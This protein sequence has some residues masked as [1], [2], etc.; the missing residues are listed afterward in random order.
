MGGGGGAEKIARRKVI[1]RMYG[2][3]EKMFLPKIDQEKNAQKS[4]PPPPT[5]T[6]IPPP[7][8]TTIPHH[9]HHHNPSPA[10]PMD[11]S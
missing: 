10:D 5:T 2:E 11:F 4:H 9:H 3:T 7:T 8:T 1:K 6:T